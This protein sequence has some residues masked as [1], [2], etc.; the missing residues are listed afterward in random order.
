[1]Q[2]PC[3]VIIAE[4]LGDE[5]RDYDMAGFTGLGEVNALTEMLNRLSEAQLGT[6]V[7][8]TTQSQSS[9]AVIYENLVILGGPDVNS[10]ALKIKNTGI[11]G[12]AIERD[13]NDENVVRDLVKAI[14]YKPSRET[15]HVSNVDIV[16]DYGIIIRAR[17]P[18]RSDRAILLIAGAYGYGVIAG[19]QVCVKNADRFKRFLRQHPDGFEC[20]VSYSMTERPP[21]ISRIEMLRP[22]SEPSQ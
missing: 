14:Q 11:S 12:V 21:G 4:W 2:E 17:N 15:D 1:M 16:R 6:R 3:S 9:P 18:F 22:L 8:L 13:S 7:A 5:M 10:A 19:M 20:I